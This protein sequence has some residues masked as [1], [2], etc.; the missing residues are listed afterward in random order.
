MKSFK[1]L[2]LSLTILFS[3]ASSAQNHTTQ[4]IRT[5]A[6]NLINYGRVDTL[7][8]FNATPV[9]IDTLAITDNTVGIIEVTVAGSTSAG[10]GATGKLIYRY[11]KA[12]GTLTVATADSASAVT[13]DSGIS[14]AGFALA[15][16][17]YN[18]AKLTITG[19]SSTTIRWKSV[20]TPYINR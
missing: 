4:R 2:L 17:T 1:I 6:G 20:M 3:V 12:A 10:V 14:G 7:T 16:N 8:T 9:V 15:A 18:N 13:V 19:K 11:A 5:T